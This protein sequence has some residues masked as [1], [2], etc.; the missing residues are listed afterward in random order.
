[1]R[2]AYCTNVRLPTERAHGHQV[3]SVCQAIH[4]LGHALTVFAPYR[5]RTTTLDFWEYHSLSREIGFQQLGSFDPIA[6]PWLP[7]VLGLFFMNISFGRALRQHLHS[8]R[9]D[10]LYTR[11]FALLPS[12][13]RTRI[14]VVLELH[15]LPRFWRNAF[16]R[17]CNRCAQIVCL[18]HPM[19]KE[20]RSWGVDAERIIVEGDAVDLDLF[21]TA[22]KKSDARRMYG[23]QDD[24]QVIVYAGQLRSMGL[25]KGMT[26]LLTAL[27]IL[28][29]RNRPFVALI[30]G[31]PPSE[32]TIL[33]HQYPILASCVRFLGPIPHTSI[34]TVLS[35]ADVLV[36]PAPRSDHPFYRRDTSPLKLFEYMASR[37]PIVCA[38]L[39]PLRDIIDTETATLVPPGD[40]AQLALGI[41]AVLDDMTTALQRADSAFHRVQ[42]HTWKERMKRILKPFSQK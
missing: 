34:P 19:A 17:S 27:S 16:V 38:D 20:L 5:H 39:E 29:E 23:I 18:T 24:M 1:M 3:A 37:R 22:P 8:S 7:G 41:E 6:S 25:S 11:S 14:P 12:L 30:A 33:Q 36:Y 9:F 13:L 35:T 42:H 4:S 26:E 32:V 40:G 15:S 10:L 28:Q 31:G 2:I 21:T